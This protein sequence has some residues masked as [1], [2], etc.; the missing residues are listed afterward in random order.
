TKYYEDRDVFHCLENSES[1]D[2]VDPSVADLKLDDLDSVTTL[3]V[4]GFGKVD[5]VRVKHNRSLVFALK[6]CSK[7]FV[8]STRQEQHIN[9][10]RIV[11]RVASKHQFVIKLYRTFKDDHNVYF[12]LE[13][14]LGGE[15]WTLLRHRGAFEELS[16]R[17]YI[18]CVVE[19]LRYLHCHQII[20]RDL[21]PENCILDKT[22]YLKITD[23]GFSKILTGGEKTW[24]FCGTPEYVAPEII[25]NKGHDQAVDF[26]S[27]GILLYELLTG[28]PPFT[29]PDP[30][31]T[32]NIIL[33]GFDAIGFEEAIFSKNCVNLIRRLCKENPSE[34]IG[35]QKNGYS[36]L[37]SHKWFSGFDWDQLIRRQIKPPIVPRL[38]SATDTH[39]FD[40]TPDQTLKEAEFDIKDGAIDLDIDCDKSWDKYF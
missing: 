38:N 36:D 18:G 1:D 21:K 27:I 40:V 15:L 19:A 12:L 20:Y 13:A 32:Y 8:R 9:N 24:T 35:V 26:W 31:K 3:G 10:E 11:Q 4:G 5:L 16:A 25:L 22:G 28:M 2:C 6:S 39:Y 34:R 29:S 7:A 17:F 37:K 23:F 30:L 14:A 33:R